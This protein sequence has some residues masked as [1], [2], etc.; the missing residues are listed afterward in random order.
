MTIFMLKYK[1][2]QIH[3]KNKPYVIVQNGNYGGN[4]QLR[5]SKKT[6]P[7]QNYQNYQNLSHEKMRLEDM[8]RHLQSQLNQLMHLRNTLRNYE[9]ET[10][11]LRRQVDYYRN[12]VPVMNFVNE[13][14]SVKIVIGATKEDLKRA[15]N[16][17]SNKKESNDLKLRNVPMKDQFEEHAQYQFGQ[18]ITQPEEQLNLVE[19]QR[20]QAEGNFNQVLFFFRGVVCVK[21]FLFVFLFLFFVFLFVFFLFLQN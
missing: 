14:E 18:K 5:S 16:D 6:I 7:D 3:K 21:P 4:S 20:L 19:V 8:N 10:N 2:Q 1:T 9:Q 15:I 13:V 11:E 12:N 17:M